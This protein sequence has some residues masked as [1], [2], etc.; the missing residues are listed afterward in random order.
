[1]VFCGKVIISFTQ[2]QS[3]EVFPFSPAEVR[4]WPLDASAHIIHLTL[5]HTDL[6]PK[7]SLTLQTGG[8]T[9]W[10]PGRRAQSRGW[11]TCA[12]SLTS[13]S[14]GET[15][16]SL[17][18]LW[19]SNLA[20]AHDVIGCLRGIGMAWSLWTWPWLFKFRSK[21][22]LIYPFLFF[23]WNRHKNCHRLKLARMWL[24]F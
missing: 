9:A 24:N 14:S 21:A 20:D 2:A 23:V 5:C 8:Q 16:P 4:H 18:P 15:M 1:M 7:K 19:P 22:G 12:A 13:S 3:L 10:L 17:I 6:L 11:G